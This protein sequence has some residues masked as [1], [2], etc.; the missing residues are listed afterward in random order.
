MFDR[1][2]KPDTEEIV[3]S[4]DPKKSLKYVRNSTYVRFMIEKILNSEE[5]ADDLDDS[6]RLS[7]FVIV[8]RLSNK[9]SGRALSV[10][11]ILKPEQKMFYRMAPESKAAEFLIQVDK[12]Q[13]ES[14][15]V[16]LQERM[17]FDQLSLIFLDVENAKYR[18]AHA[19]R[20]NLKVAKKFKR[21]DPETN[22]VLYA[23]G[24]KDKNDAQ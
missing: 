6:L 13:F 15:D 16:E 17:L 4:D 21:K 14:L 2:A 9:A 19:V 5:Y 23:M 1:T 8:E 18:L 24:S 20:V 10:L 12:V 22:A 11:K 3:V 7:Q